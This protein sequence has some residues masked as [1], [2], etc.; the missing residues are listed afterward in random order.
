VGPKASAK[1]YVKAFRSKYDSV[2]KGALIA[3]SKY[4]LEKNDKS[5][6]EILTTTIENDQV[7]KPY[8]RTLRSNEHY[9]LIIN[10]EK[11]KLKGQNIVIVKIEKKPTLKGDFMN[12]DREL[13]SDGIEES[14]LLYRI[15]REVSIDKAVEKIYK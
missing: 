1:P 4:P 14:V 10:L 12:D 13:E 9:K 5:S 11:R 7:F 15:S 6:G 2:W 8:N 3:L